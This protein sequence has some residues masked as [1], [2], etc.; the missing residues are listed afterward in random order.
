[1]VQ[2]L[3]AHSPENERLQNI[4]NALR[5]IRMLTREKLISYL[6]EL[7]ELAKQDCV[8]LEL[9]IYG[10]AAFLLAYDNRAATKDVDA[11]VRPESIAC[12]Y[13]RKLAEKHQLPDDWLNSAVAQFLTPHKPTLRRIKEIEQFKNLSVRVP[14]ARYLLALKAMACREPIGSYQGD[15]QDLRFLIKKMNVRTTDEIQ[16]AIDAYFPDDVLDEER[17][18]VLSS[19]IEEAHG[20][21]TA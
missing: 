2:S 1:M 9:D 19:L 7:D 4:S 10:G 13:I 3:A 11:I 16:K 6:A 21:P 14:T 18:M 15:Y 5:F 17:E 8:L 12:G 20:S